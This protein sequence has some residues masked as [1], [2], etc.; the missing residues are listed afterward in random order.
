M[1]CKMARWTQ[2]TNAYDYDDELMVK[3]GLMM[4]GIDYIKKLE[5]EEQI[6]INSF[7]EVDE[8]RDSFMITQYKI[9]INNITNRHL[10]NNKIMSKYIQDKETEILTLFERVLEDDD[11]SAR[12][13]E[14]YLHSITLER[15][16][17]RLIRLISYTPTT[18][19]GY[20]SLYQMLY[21]EIKRAI[22][23]YYVKDESKV[24][25]W[26]FYNNPH[27]LGKYVEFFTTKYNFIPIDT[28]DKPVRKAASIITY[29]LTNKKPNVKND[30][31][32]DDLHLIL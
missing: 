21:H 16:T 22:E 15:N 24:A 18:T 9:E 28:T 8:V 19:K 26:K 10:N 13:A 6:L 2:K 17:E 23:W 30:I 1:R 27:C 11:S 25:K 31:P 29:L 4:A 12:L 32:K 20:I 7:L 5:K 14:F 3:G